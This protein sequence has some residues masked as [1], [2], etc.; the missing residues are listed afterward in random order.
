MY[1]VV[2]SA[3]HILA[4]GAKNEDIGATVGV[5]FERI[6]GLSNEVKD[7]AIDAHIGKA[8]VAPDEKACDACGQ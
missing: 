6:V 3:L 5:G 2:L 1:S 8:E 4:A 7:I